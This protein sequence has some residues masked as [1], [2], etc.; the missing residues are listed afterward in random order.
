MFSSFGKVLHLK[1][2]ILIIIQ[3]VQ[4]ILFF[5]KLYAF[6]PLYLNFHIFFWMYSHLSFIST[7]IHHYLLFSRK[8][9]SADTLIHIFLLVSPLPSFHHFQSL[10]ILISSLFPKHSECSSFLSTIKFFPSDRFQF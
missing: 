3:N 7:W 4:H 6:M 1:K 8:Q 5:H 9:K 10:I 2:Q